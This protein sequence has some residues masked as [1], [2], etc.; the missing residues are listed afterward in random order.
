M[1]CKDCDALYIRY[2]LAARAIWGHLEFTPP[3]RKAG[4]FMIYDPR[5]GTTNPACSPTSAWTQLPYI[6]Q[7]ENTT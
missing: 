4:H 3:R 7:E 6:V 5:N 2:N 1:N